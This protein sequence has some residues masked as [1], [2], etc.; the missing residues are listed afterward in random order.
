M[1]TPDQQNSIATRTESNPK[2][3]DGQGRY[4][5]SIET[6]ERDAEA[7][8]LRSRGFTYRQIAAALGVEVGPAYEMV[9]RAIHD[10]IA[11][12]AEDAR[13]ME[14]ERLDGILQR[15]EVQED[16]VRKVLARKHYVFSNGR[17]LYKDGEEEPLEDDDVVLRAVAQLGAIEDRRL[18]VTMSRA[19]LLGLKIPVKQEVEVTG[20]EYRIIGI[21]LGVL[22]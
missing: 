3:R 16:L 12:P 18:R 20:V 10:V 7:A 1:T 19:E 17:L 2:T 14:V 8:R 9:K 15:L 4:T 6:A 5:R 13:R 22:S 21:N 11:E